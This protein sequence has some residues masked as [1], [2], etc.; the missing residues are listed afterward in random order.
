MKPVTIIGG[1]LAGLAAANALADSGA[2]ITLIERAHT[3]GGRARTTHEHG[4]SINFGPHALY[5]GGVTNRMLAEW[6]ISISATAPAP[7][8]LACFV[9]SNEP[10][11]F[12]R[13]IDNILTNAADVRPE[14]SVETWL[15]RQTQSEDLRASLRT[16][17]RVS[18]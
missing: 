9:K 13:D 15:A 2:K 12:V 1:G 8:P 14:D 10:I 18:N 4:Y 16:V 5:K 11:P 7:G 17:F 3:L 6:G